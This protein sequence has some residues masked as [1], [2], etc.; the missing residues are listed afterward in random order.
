MGNE[1]IESNVGHQFISGVNNNSNKSRRVHKSI[2]AP[3]HDR[4]CVIH[5]AL[6]TA[7]FS[8]FYQ[9]LVDGLLD[10]SEFT[11]TETFGPENGAGGSAAA[12]TL[13]GRFAARHHPRHGATA[14]NGRRYDR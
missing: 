6:G 14:P 7:S 11:K 2:D 3:A 13:Y 10:R 1:Q 12:P 4:P 8:A 5:A 9:R